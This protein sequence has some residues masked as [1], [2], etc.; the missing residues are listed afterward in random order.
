MY[1]YILSAL[2]TICL[3]IAFAKA[4]EAYKKHKA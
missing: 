1:S 4:W 2:L 3:I